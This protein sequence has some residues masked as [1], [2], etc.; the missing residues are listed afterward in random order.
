METKQEWIYGS[1][2]NEGLL[3]DWDFCS[4]CINLRIR[5]KRPLANLKSD[6]ITPP[7]FRV[8][9]KNWKPS[10]PRKYIK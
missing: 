7:Y 2:L 1:K 5:N 4:T 8:K 9:H 6:G 10:Q 3:C